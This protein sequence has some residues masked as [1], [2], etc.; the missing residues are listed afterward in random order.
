M[1]HSFS[2]V[3]LLLALKKPFCYIFPCEGVE[4]KEKSFIHCLCL[5]IFTEKLRNIGCGF[6]W[7]YDL[8]HLLSLWPGQSVSGGMHELIVSSTGIPILEL[9][10]IWWDFW[11]R[12]METYRVFTVDYLLLHRGEII[13]FCESSLLFSH[14]SWIKWHLI[15]GINQGLGVLDRVL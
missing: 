5:N 7:F 6:N 14:H 13:T 9:E 1:S 12:S 15:G 4:K 11:S 3:S 10:N 8:Y 2:L